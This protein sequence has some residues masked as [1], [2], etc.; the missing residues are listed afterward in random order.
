MLGVAASS[1][2]YF[3]RAANIAH[4]AVLCKFLCQ[5]PGVSELKLAPKTIWGLQTEV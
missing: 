1:R 5:E 4:S 2:T 3:L